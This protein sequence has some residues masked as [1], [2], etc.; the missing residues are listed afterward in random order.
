ML[1]YI[2]PAALA[3]FV[4]LILWFVKKERLSLDYDIVESDLFPRDGGLGKYFVC[5]LRNAGNRAIEDTALKI[6]INEGEID[7]VEYSNTELLHIKEK[8]NTSI[9]ANIPLLN[10]KERV[11]A[12][13]T[14]KN[15][16]EHSYPSIE[17][18]AVGV[19]ASRKSNESIPGYFQSIVVA[20][21]I[22]ITAS[23]AFS[24]WNTFTQSKVVSSI[25]MFGE[26]AGLTEK[27]DENRKTL[28]ELEKEAD[29]IKIKREQG[30]PEREQIV[31][32]IINRAGLSEV[33]PGLIAISG[34][35]LPYWKTGLHL[36]HSYLLDENNSN[37]YVQS[38]LNLAE[39]EYIAPSSKG[40][41][42]YLAGKIEK[43]EGHTDK[44]I[45]YL[46]K[47]KALTPLMYEH[48]MSQDPAYDLDSVKGWLTKNH[49]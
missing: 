45:Q 8:S 5:S 29:Q 1:Q 41:L 4:G 18:R 31:L 20:L 25:E 6:V 40:F 15:A 35:G 33:I 43:R 19:T 34:E 11:S 49:K 13:I 17:A 9:T 39:V 28:E 16:K 2:I 36:L 3:F 47:C 23:M 44:A 37:K 7:S 32:S 10:P 12:I 14:I 46:E 38:L 21:A 30:D 26:V 22:G 48:L 24:T 42:L 27:I